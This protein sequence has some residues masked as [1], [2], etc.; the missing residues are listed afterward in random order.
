MPL[1]S[2]HSPQQLKKVEDGKGRNYQV[3][4]IYLVLKYIVL[5]LSCQ[6]IMAYM[7]MFYDFVIGKVSTFVRE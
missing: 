2:S 7:L 5:T 3:L 1:I 6:G 4:H